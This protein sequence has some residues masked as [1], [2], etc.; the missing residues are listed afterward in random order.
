MAVP[1]QSNGLWLHCIPSFF[2]VGGIFVL[3]VVHGT[4]PEQGAE[5]PVHALPFWA[6]GGHCIV[7][8]G[9]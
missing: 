2:F 6:R 3:V 4:R 7:S 1:G 5:A 9:P 8:G